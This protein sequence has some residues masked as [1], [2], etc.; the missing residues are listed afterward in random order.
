[1]A[2]SSC[3][4][5]NF[6]DDDDDNNDAATIF[7]TQKRFKFAFRSHTQLPKN[8]NNNNKEQTFS[9]KPTSLH[10]LLF[11]VPR[12]RRKPKRK[13]ATAHRCLY[14]CITTE[15][16]LNLYLFAGCMDGGGGCAIYFDQHN[17]INIKH[18]DARMAHKIEDDNDHGNH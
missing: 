11:S 7:F 13:K 15:T 5:S 10:Y 12:K 16:R 8:N 18:V 14:E 3:A 9:T 4:W 6:V 2:F 17:L 1:M